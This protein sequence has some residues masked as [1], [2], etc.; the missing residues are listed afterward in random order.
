MFCQSKIIFITLFTSR[1]TAFARLSQLRTYKGAKLFSWTK[2]AHFDF[3]SSDCNVQGHILSSSGD[4]LR[5]GSLFSTFC[6]QNRVVY[7][8]EDYYFSGQW[9]CWIC[10]LVWICFFNYLEWTNTQCVQ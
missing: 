3:P 6:K 9:D 7:R 2:P 1:C 4:A 8:P 5:M 10:L